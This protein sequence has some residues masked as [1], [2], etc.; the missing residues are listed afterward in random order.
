VVVLLVSVCVRVAEPAGVSMRSVVVVRER[1]VVASGFEVSTVTFGAGAAGGFTMVVEEVD[2]ATG[3][4]RCTTVSFVGWT[5]VV[6]EVL[7]G[8][9]QPARA[10]TARTIAAG[11]AYLI[12]VSMRDGSP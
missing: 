10:A 7:A 5:T 3:T 9:S 11:R 1:S 8:R 6:D 4:S 2:G 12:E